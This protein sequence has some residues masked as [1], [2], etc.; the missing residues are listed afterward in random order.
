MRRV[1]IEVEGSAQGAVEKLRKGGVALLS[2]EKKGKNAVVLAVDG[3]DRK[4]VFAILRQPCYNIKKVC[5]RGLERFRSKCKEGVGFLI[6][7]LVVLPAI[8]FAQ[9]R[10]LRIEVEGS[11]TYLAR[12]V[13]AALQ[14]EGVSLFSSVPE[15]NAIA[16]RIFSLP[17]V[18]FVSMKAEGGVLAVRVEVEREPSV[19]PSPDLL[20]PISGV[21]EELIVLRGTPLVSVGDTV[22]KG[23][24]LVGG[25]ALYGEEVRAVEIVARAKISF[26]VHK[27][28]EGDE[29]SARAQAELDYGE[30]NGLT[31][32][33]AEGG[34]LIE[35]TG[36]EV[37]GANFG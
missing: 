19:L 10:V 5:P 16:A 35:G 21:V 9:S 24:P 25:Y 22:E 17:D 2:A 29:E 20:S 23:A 31:V 27:F 28:Y 7:A 3:K 15:G 33:P 11:G 14:E 37:V 1:E 6:G 30:L 34:Y 4:K 26:F 12:E 13:K 36:F 18:C 8:L 32:S